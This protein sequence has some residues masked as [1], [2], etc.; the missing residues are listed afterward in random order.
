MSID[1]LAGREKRCKANE[2][3][4]CAAARSFT[5]AAQQAFQEKRVNAQA[6]L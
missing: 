6:L 5:I 2:T 1:G 4:L 3:F